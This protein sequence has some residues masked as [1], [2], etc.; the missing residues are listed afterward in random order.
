MTFDRVVL[1]LNAAFVFVT[2]IGCIVVPASVAQQAGLSMA[3][4]ALTEIRAFYGGILVGTGCFLVW[5]LRRP[6]RTFAGLLMVLLTVGGAGMARILGMLIDRAP[7]AYHL[8]NLGV[9][10]TTV[11]LVAVAITRARPVADA[12]VVSPAISR[13]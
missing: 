7:T 2:G 10:I 12:E 5:C 13:R 3:P 6:T 11:T 8:T 4:S 1:A 9:E